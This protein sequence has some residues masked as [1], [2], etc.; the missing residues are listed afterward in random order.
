MKNFYNEKS[1]CRKKIKEDIRKL[2]AISYAYIGRT[3]I[4]KMTTYPK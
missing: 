4:V 2:E 3:N 1:Y